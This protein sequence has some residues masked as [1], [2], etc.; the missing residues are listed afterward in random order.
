MYKIIIVLLLAINIY[1]QDYNYSLQTSDIS[2]FNL[3]VSN[4]G[5]FGWKNSNI[6]TNDCIMWPGG[7]YASISFSWVFGFSWCGIVNNQTRVYPYGIIQNYKPGK[8]LDNGNSD[9]PALSKYRVYKIKKNWEQMPS[10]PERDQMEKDYNE[11]PVEDGAPW[12]DNNNDH[13]YTRGI[14]QPEFLGDEVLWYVSNDAELKRKNMWGFPSQWDSIYLNLEIQNTAYAFG[15][16]GILGDA[17]FIKSKIINKSQNVIN[18]YLISVEDVFMIGVT[19]SDT[20]LSTYDGINRDIGLVYEYPK[21]NTRWKNYYSKPVAGGDLLLQGPVQVSDNPQ[22]SGFVDG[23]WR[24]GCH[25]LGFYSSYAPLNYDTSWHINDFSYHDQMYNRM[26]GLHPNGQPIINVVTGNPTKFMYDGDP[27]TNTGWT[28]SKGGFPG[29]GEKY[30]TFGTGFFFQIGPVDLHPYDTVEIVIAKIAATGNTNLEALAEL[31]RR[32]KLLKHAYEQN[33]RTTSLM[34]TPVL[35]TFPDEDKVTLWWNGN[36]E[37]YESID[38]FLTGQNYSD[39]TYNFEGYRVWQYRDST[40][41]DGRVIATYDKSDGVGVIEDYQILNGVSVKVPVIFGN[42]LGLRRYM[43]I[44]ND[45]YTK[46]KLYNGNPYYFGVTSYSYSPFSSPSYLESSPRILKIIPGRQKIDYKSKYTNTGKD[47]ALQVAGQANAEISIKVLDPI[48]ITG[49][50]YEIPFTTWESKIS[51]N[52]INVTR[53]DTL[54]R[55][56]Q[57][58]TTD[59]LY[60]PVSDGFMVMVYLTDNKLVSDSL[61]TKYGIKSVREIDKE[62]G[63]SQNVYENLDNTG[64]WKIISTYGIQGAGFHEQNLNQYDNIGRD[65]YEIRFTSGGSEYYSE[66]GPL[67]NNSPKGKGRVPFEVWDIT[68]GERLLIKSADWFMVRDS[69]WSQ[70]PKTKNWKMITVFRGSLPYIEPLPDTSGLLSSNNILI[71]NIVLNGDLPQEGTVI[72]IVTFKP[73][74]PGD[75]YRITTQKAKLADLQAGKEN[76]NKISVFPNPYFG[77]NSI[78]EPGEQNYVRFTGLPTKAVIRIYTLAGLYV[79]SIEKDGLNQYMDWNLKTENGTSVASG[80]YIAHIE[81]PGIGEKILKLAV[82]MGKEY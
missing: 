14:D 16:T 80:I 56:N 78:R 13:I 57:D 76:I 41:T 55:N 79:R 51:Y 59:T 34:P 21:S 4:L 7:R 58:Y 47:I 25:N 29:T 71:Y 27:F 74:L 20:T 6:L 37:S 28:Q 19:G 81:M 1:S 61:H 40:G 36:A 72:R 77:E 65:D 62:T 30:S 66:P 54:F 44:T 11:W 17:V 73:V 75:K 24:K 42:D 26:Q 35:N 2:Q 18:H 68:T 8:I 39:T 53:G 5:L 82:I 45:V 32:A 67:G 38:P 70:D 9:D 46:E 15:S 12:K 64:K 49:D 10:G 48:A 31:Y 3:P 23:L 69:I 60:K 33:F 50:E 63:L 43:V 22:D 52:M